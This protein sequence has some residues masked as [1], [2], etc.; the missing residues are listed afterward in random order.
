MLTKH[1]TAKSGGGRWWWLFFSATEWLSSI[2][3][4]IRLTHEDPQQWERATWEVGFAFFPCL[5]EEW[6]HCGHGMGWDWADYCG[7]CTAMRYRLEICSLATL[8]CIQFFQYLHFSPFTQVRRE[9]LLSEKRMMKESGRYIRNCYV[10]L[11][12]TGFLEGEQG[13]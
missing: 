6:N 10:L 7:L 8:L 1:M 13:S 4:V 9:S 3:V 5:V 12:V 11:L 2:L